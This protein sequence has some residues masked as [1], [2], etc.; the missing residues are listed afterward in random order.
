LPGDAPSIIRELDPFPFFLEGVDVESLLLLGSYKFPSPFSSFFSY[1]KDRQ[2]HSSITLIRRNFFLLISPLILRV[3]MKATPMLVLN[4]V[5]V[6]PFFDFRGDFP[7]PPTIRFMSRCRLQNGGCFPP[8]PFSLF[9]SF[10][11]S[12]FGFCAVVFLHPSPPRLPLIFFNFS[13]WEIGFTPPVTSCPLAFSTAPLLFSPPFGAL[14]EPRSYAN[15]PLSP[16][17][18][19]FFL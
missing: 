18:N 13:V 8:P 5:G 16:F 6:S 19:P 7:L 10:K 14:P 1:F 15:S 11:T 2:R 9:P 3:S 17:P 12:L 4:G